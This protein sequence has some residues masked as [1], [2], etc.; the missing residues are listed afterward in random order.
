[1]TFPRS[2]WPCSTATCLG[3]TV[4]FLQPD[5]VP[6]KIF[7]I[8][9]AFLWWKTDLEDCPASA[10]SVMVPQTDCNPATTN[11]RQS[12]HYSHISCQNLSYVAHSAMARNGVEISLM[13]WSQTRHSCPDHSS[14]SSLEKMYPQQQ[15]PRLL[16][17]AWSSHPGTP[18]HTALLLLT[19]IL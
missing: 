5:S 3:D 12:K 9:P 18:G 13:S 7:L 16:P 1:M 8:P 17:A 4:L 15:G 11:L 2:H 14:P 6:W 10:F 19:R